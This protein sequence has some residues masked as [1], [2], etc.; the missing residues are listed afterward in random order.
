[1]V[2]VG[3]PVLLMSCLLLFLNS[4]PGTRYSKPL[5]SPDQKR[6]IRVRTFDG[7]LGADGHDE[8]ELFTKHGFASNDV[9]T[10]EVYSVELD[11]IQWTDSG[12]LKIQHQ[13]PTSKCKD[14]ESVTVICA[15]AVG[16]PQ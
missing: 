6:A 14:T 10:G 5:Y 7:G 12:H 15:L 1:M 13:D 8:V 3:V 11:N 2:I 9:Y 16:S 4:L